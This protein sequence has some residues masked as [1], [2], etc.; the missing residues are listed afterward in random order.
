VVVIIYDIHEKGKNRLYSLASQLFVP[1]LIFLVG[2]GA[3]GIGLLVKIEK[4]KVPISIEYPALQEAS[5]SK[6]FS[7]TSILYKEPNSLSPPQ[8][9]KQKEV[10]QPAIQSKIQSGMFVAA[11]G[12]V[13]YYYPWCSAVKRISEKNKIWFQT[14]EAAVLAGFKPATNCKGMK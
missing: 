4:G 7:Q 8:S 10:V 3:Y 14:K 2:S 1:L 6:S 13:A 12:G 11:R 5:S 9:P